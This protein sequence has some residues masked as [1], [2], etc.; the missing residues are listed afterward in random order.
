MWRVLQ[1]GGVGG[2]W[3]GHSRRWVGLMG[4]V[5]ILTSMWHQLISCGGT[6]YDIMSH[7]ILDMWEGGQ[8]K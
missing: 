2:H 8:I 3:V 7:T 5:R 1:E 4:G 6:N